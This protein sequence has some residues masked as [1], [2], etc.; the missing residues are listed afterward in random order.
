MLW[1]LTTKLSREAVNLRAKYRKKMM[2]F[3]KT[4][5]WTKMEQMLAQVPKTKHLQMHRLVN[6]KILHSND[7]NMNKVNSISKRHKRRNSLNLDPTQ[8]QQMKKKNYSNLLWVIWTKI[9]RS[10]KNLQRYK[11]RTKVWAKSRR[12]RKSKMAARKNLNKLK[13]PRTLQS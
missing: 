4:H 12:V 5:K 6:K 13:H 11:T 3:L 1:R 9:P 7:K 10:Q 8:K 2:S